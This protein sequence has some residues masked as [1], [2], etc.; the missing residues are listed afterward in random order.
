MKG[1]EIIT[2][3]QEQFEE[4]K[5]EIKADILK[6]LSQKTFLE[7]HE[8]LNLWSIIKKEIVHQIECSDRKINSV[9]LAQL[10]NLIS[11][12]IR[13]R[14]GINHIRFLNKEQLSEALETAQKALE[15]MN[16]QKKESEAK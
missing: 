14:F 8:G 13:W 10:I 7:K 3:T 16:F 6:E 12:I 2:L 15:L 4:L 1:A 11:A 5:D 9:E